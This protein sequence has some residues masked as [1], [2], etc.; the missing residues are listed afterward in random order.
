MSFLSAKV[1]VS[2]TYQQYEAQQLIPVSTIVLYCYRLFYYAA[3]SSMI[4][5]C[6]AS[7]SAPY[8]SVLV[9]PVEIGK[10]LKNL[11]LP[12]SGLERDC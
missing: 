8:Y 9:S 12:P 5:V 4:N 6:T 7:G 11:L 2:V 3:S 1:N 10:Q